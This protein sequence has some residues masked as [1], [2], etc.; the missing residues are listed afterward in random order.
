M[1]KID[2]FELMFLAEAC[3]PERPI[4]RAMFW[5]K[6][7]DEYYHDMTDSE[8]ANAHRWINL[9]YTYERGIEDGIGDVL[10]FEARYNPNNQY[11]VKTDYKGEKKDYECFYYNNNYH[12][13]IRTSIQ[14]EYITSVQLKVFQ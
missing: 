3:I 8:R 4:A 11:I 5:R 10:L 7:I 13:N 6:M 9:N 12:T 2:F 14:E 1:F